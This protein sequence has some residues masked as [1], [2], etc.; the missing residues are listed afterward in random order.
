M[1]RRPGAQSGYPSPSP[2]RTCRTSSGDA[3]YL[4]RRIGREG[5]RAGQPVDETVE[6]GDQDGQLVG[7]LALQHDLGAVGPDDPHQLDLDE[8]G[9]VVALAGGEILGQ[10]GVVERTV[11][12]DV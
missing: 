1:R 11:A 7:T 5:P 8:G 12:H 10:P 4:R 3:P 2:S 6:D 9:G